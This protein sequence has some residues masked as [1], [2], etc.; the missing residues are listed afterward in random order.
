MGIMNDLGFRAA[1]EAIIGLVARGEKPTTEN[2]TEWLNTA[3]EPNN[4]Q[5]SVDPKR[6]YGCALFHAQRMLRG[7]CPPDKGE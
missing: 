5:S 2:V 7:P 1:A 3:I 4:P 6:I